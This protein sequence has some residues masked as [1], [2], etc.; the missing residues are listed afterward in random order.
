[1]APSL[2]DSYSKELSKLPDYTSKTLTR[3][4]Y[5]IAPRTHALIR[6]SEYQLTG[7]NIPPYCL[8]VT[9]VGCGTEGWYQEYAL[10]CSLDGQS[11]QEVI[12]ELLDS[13]MEKDEDDTV[14]ARFTY[15]PFGFQDSQG[16]QQGMQITGAFV[17]PGYDK[18]GLSSAVYG[19]L[20]NWYEHI[21]CDNKQTVP[22]AKIWAR[23][24]LTVGRV[25]I[26]NAR[27]PKFVDVLAKGGIGCGNVKPWDGL[28]LTQAQLAD[29]GGNHLN[30]ETCI[31]VVNIISARDKNVQIGLSTFQPGTGRPRMIVIR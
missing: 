22:G 19:F 1:M 3:Q 15:L 23:G 5:L 4:G 31:N 26:Y 7:I 17:K 24:M 6:L 30:H 11:E 14:I 21:V 29:W 13:G 8:I 9:E 16:P 10:E 2:I 27:I 12:A 25:Q 20:L 28:N 18:K